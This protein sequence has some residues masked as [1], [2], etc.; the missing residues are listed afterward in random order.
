MHILC[1]K[2]GVAAE[3]FLP[4]TCVTRSST[5]ILTDEVQHLL[6]PRRPSGRVDKTVQR[7]VARLLKT[8]WCY[9]SRHCQWTVTGSGMA[10]FW[11]L[12]GLM[13]AN[14]ISPLTHRLT[15]HLPHEHSEEAKT[16]VLQHLLAADGKPSPQGELPCRMVSVHGTPV[17]GAVLAHHSSSLVCIVCSSLPLTAFA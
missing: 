10:L 5:C 8:L 4:L 3:L 2:C 14:G 1:G 17:A 9:S 15:V 16:R 7:S 11:I 12:L 13:P 6:S